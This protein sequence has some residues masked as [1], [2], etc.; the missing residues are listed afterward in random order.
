MSQAA[1]AIDSELR[2]RANSAGESRGND[3]RFLTVAPLAIYFDVLED[4]R[5]VDVWSVFRV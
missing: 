1:D 5:T 4:D 2:S 3:A